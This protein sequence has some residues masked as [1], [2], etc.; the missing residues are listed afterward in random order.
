[1][2]PVGEVFV[3]TLG[4]AHGTIISLGLRLVVVEPAPDATART[5][6][7]LSQRWRDGGDGSRA[8]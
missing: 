7:S 5:G 8:F 6:W 2:P 4:F 1:M 3:T